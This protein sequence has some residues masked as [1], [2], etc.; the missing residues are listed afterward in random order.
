MINKKNKF[1]IALMSIGLICYCIG[2]V[3]FSIASTFIFLFSG[4]LIFVPIFFIGK[5]LKENKKILSY[6]LMIGASFF[7]IIILICLVGFLIK[8]LS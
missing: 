6:V 3:T 1:F 5:D 8:L 2:F 4:L 7:I